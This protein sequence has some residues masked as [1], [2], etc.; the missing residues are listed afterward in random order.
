MLLKAKGQGIDH[1][2]TQSTSQSHVTTS[3]DDTNP[4]VLAAATNK[5]KR[6]WIELADYQ[7]QQQQQQQFNTFPLPSLHGVHNTSPDDVF[8]PYPPPL[9]PDTPPLP[10]DRPSILSRLSGSGGSRPRTSPPSGG[11][12]GK[13]DTTTSTTHPRGH[14]HHLAHTSPGPTSVHPTHPSSQQG[15][16]T[17]TT[18]TNTYGGGG[19]RKG[20]S[21]RT[22]SPNTLYI[23]SALSLLCGRELSPKS[24]KAD[25][26]TH[27]SSSGSESLPVATGCCE[28]GA[29]GQ[30][31]DATSTAD[32][33]MGSSYPSNERIRSQSMSSVSVDNTSEE[34]STESPFRHSVH[35]LHNKDAHHEP[36]VTSKTGI[37]CLFS[38]S[39]S[40]PTHGDPSCTGPLAASTCAATNWTKPVVDVMYAVTASSAARQKHSPDSPTDMH[41]SSEVA[42][43]SRSVRVSF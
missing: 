15:P 35:I 27:T 22:A 43:S 9:R 33:L 40:P 32:R 20:I 31:E 39:I 18:T 23:A 28:E 2:V 11:S 7:Q 24:L 36:L 8:G 14:F 4:P 5:R 12:F 34:D 13:N 26:P 37:G 17:S 3:P 19:Y 41:V 29:D 21:V 30:G 25:S 38:E 6:Q 42:T 16:S 10:M 1:S